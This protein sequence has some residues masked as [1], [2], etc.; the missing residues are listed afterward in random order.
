MGTGP[1]VG[2]T[3]VSVGVT[4]P[5]ERCWH[6]GSLRSQTTSSVSPSTHRESS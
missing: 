4:F 6:G 5:P 1:I 2:P 3:G